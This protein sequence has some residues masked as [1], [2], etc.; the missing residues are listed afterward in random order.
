MISI[1]VAMTKQGV[2]GCDN[3]MPWHK[4]VDLERF[5]YLTIGK[6][7]IFGRKT[8]DAIPKPLVDRG[9]YVLTR[10]GNWDPKDEHV[11]V[12]P[13]RHL[14]EQ[15]IHLEYYGEVMICGGA[16]LYHEALILTR[17]NG[18]IDWHR[19]PYLVTRMYL[20][21]LKDNIYGNT[22]FPYFNRELWETEHTEDCGDH[23][24]SVLN[25]KPNS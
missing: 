16:S 3:Q 7:C 24:F 17:H 12:Q 5:R 18:G 11:G 1:I 22:Y 20:T 6:S 21:E 19:K 14:W 4:P 8:Y 10:N 15:L 13:I 23:I 9:C 25:R 2:I